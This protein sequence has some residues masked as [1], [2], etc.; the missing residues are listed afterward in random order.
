MLWLVV[1]F[2]RRWLDVYRAVLASPAAAEGLDSWLPPASGLRERILDI[3]SRHAGGF[4]PEVPSRGEV[5]D[6]D[7]DVANLQL[8][9][10]LV[11]QRARRKLKAVFRFSQMGIRAK[12]RV[13]A[14][15]AA[16]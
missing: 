9:R 16:G 2:V 12:A 10:H 14:A 4:R 5:E 6:V 13:E 15:S 7:W 3:A 11:L 8:Q 1:V